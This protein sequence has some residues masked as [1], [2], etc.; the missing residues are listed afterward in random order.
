M[1]GSTWAWT[2]LYLTLHFSFS[3]AN[4]TLVLTPVFCGWGFSGAVTC[5]LN[6]VS[7]ILLFI[8]TSSS[9]HFCRSCMTSA[10]VG[11]CNSFYQSKQARLAF[12]Q[13]KLIVNYLLLSWKKAFY[14]CGLQTVF[15][16]YSVWG[17]ILCGI[18]RSNLIISATF[19]TNLWGV[20][21]LSI[22]IT[23]KRRLSN[24]INLSTTPIDLWS[25]AG[26]KKRFKWIY[27]KESWNFMA[28]NVCAWSHFSLRV[29]RYSVFS[30][31]LVSK[32]PLLLCLK[33]AFV[34]FDHLSIATSIYASLFISSG[35]VPAKSNCVFR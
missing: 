29:T 21:F 20:L 26:A 35:R 28:Q 4:T 24:Y 22:P 23:P 8:V 11:G 32:R 2:L 31:A 12:F 15:F 14:S 18:M 27:L 30:V 33:L 16:S 1:F 7:R 19:E 17:V 6:V 34:N 3:R 9:Y 5:W 25:S 10:G 13:L